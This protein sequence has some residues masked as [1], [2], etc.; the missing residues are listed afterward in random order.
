M[1]KL[2]SIAAVALLAFGVTALA[3][4]KSKKKPVLKV[5][6]AAPLFVLKNLEGKEV[7]LKKVLEQKKIVVLE[8]FNPGCPY[9]KKHHLHNS[10]M[11]DLATKYK[12]KV[13]WLAINSSAE[14]KQGYGVDLNKE[15]KKNWKIPYPILMDQD[16][17]TGKAYGARRTPHMYVIN[18]E[19]KLAYIGAIDNDTSSKTPGKVNY[20]EAAVTALLS[21]KAPETKKTKSYGCGVKYGPRN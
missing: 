21:G 10:T 11:R 1:R 15:S 12:D 20:V 4:D 19:G 18:A 16:G 6:D 2:V 14:G 13:V 9:V 3:G 5:G 17:K 7:S 8:W